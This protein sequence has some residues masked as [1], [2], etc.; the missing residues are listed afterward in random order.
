MGSYDDDEV[1]DYIDTD[2]VEVDEAV[3]VAV[4]K[5]LTDDDCELVILL[6]AQYLQLVEVDDDEL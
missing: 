2:E 1:N 6:L 3:V 4:L 5:E